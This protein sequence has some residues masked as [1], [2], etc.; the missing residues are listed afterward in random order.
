MDQEKALN[1]IADSRQA[2]LKSIQDLNERIM[3]DQAV[4]GE[5]TI[6]DLLAHI[7]A[8]DEICLAPM[9]KFNQNMPFQ[10]EI[11]EDSDI[12]NKP[13]VDKRQEQSV[14]TILRELTRIRLELLA[15]TQRLDDTQWK[16][17]IEMPWG[18]EKGTVTSLLSRLAS[19][20]NKHAQSILKFREDKNL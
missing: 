10:P 4:E 7:I 1:E 12:W 3:T 8:W 20:E 15:A 18:G 17:S 2:L 14:G 5:W 19:H 13:Q 9:R 11:V 16:M 6:K